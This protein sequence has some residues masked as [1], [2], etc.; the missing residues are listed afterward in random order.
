[1]GVLGFVMAAPGLE[2]DSGTSV[3]SQFEPFRGYWCRFSAI[4]C[5]ALR[6][7]RDWNWL[8]HW[9]PS[10]GDLGGPW[11]SG[12][13]AC[14]GSWPA[15]G[16]PSVPSAPGPLGVDPVPVPWGGSSW[17]HPSPSQP[18][19]VGA[20]PSPRVW[21]WSLECPI[22]GQ[23]PCLGQIPQIHHPGTMGSWAIPPPLPAPRGHSRLQ[24][25]GIHWQFLV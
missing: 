11:G 23:G 17:T 2:W 3:W 25:V 4:R 19:P 14:P 16:A 10:E 18:I 7:I 12:S 22:P 15:S 8:W 6:W 20:A 21:H 13:S 9:V 1:M 24:G 5:R